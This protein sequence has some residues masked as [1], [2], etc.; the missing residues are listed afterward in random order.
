MEEWLQKKMM[1]KGNNFVV[2][3]F[4]DFKTSIFLRG[5]NSVKILKILK[6][7][8]TVK[9][10]SRKNLTI[11]YF[12]KKSHSVFEKSVFPISHSINLKVV[13]SWWVLVHK[14]DNNFERGFW[15]IYHF[16]TKFDQLIDIV[17]D[18]IFSKTFFMI[19]RTRS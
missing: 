18:N 9:I 15:I 19:W 14:L 6:I 16:A 10:N 2:F 17:M 4:R 13:T 1:K 12:R 5:G 3:H 7:V 11:S 8:K